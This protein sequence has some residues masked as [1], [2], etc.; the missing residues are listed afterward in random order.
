MANETIVEEQGS[1]FSR[2]LGYV[3]SCREASD[4][5][6]KSLDSL[7]SQINSLASL[8]EAI[9][10][11]EPE[12]ILR[13]NIE[14]IK[15]QIPKDKRK[16]LEIGEGGISFKAPPWHENITKTVSGMFRTVISA[17]GLLLPGVFIWIASKIGGKDK[18]WTGWKDKMKRFREGKE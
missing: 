4:E 9:T 1:L 12:K 17:G 16:D 11:E 2:A 14:D 7:I 18:L 8:F 5:N 13:E 10:G 6:E 15:K 3:A